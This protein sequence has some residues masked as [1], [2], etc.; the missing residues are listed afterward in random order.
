MKNK[1]T[2]RPQERVGLVEGNSEMSGAC[3]RVKCVSSQ[4]AIEGMFFL[5]DIVVKTNA[6][7]VGDG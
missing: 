6:F 1:K 2:S 7:D 5:P 3:E 4:T